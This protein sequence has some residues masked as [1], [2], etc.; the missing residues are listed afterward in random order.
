MRFS[1]WTPVHERVERE[2]HTSAQEIRMKRTRLHQSNKE[3]L[4]ERTAAKA[5]VV[6]AG[7]RRL[8]FACGAPTKKEVYVTF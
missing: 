8:L 7:T 1:S 5:K 4:L 2:T 6:V 3:R